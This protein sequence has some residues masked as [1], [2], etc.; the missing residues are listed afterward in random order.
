MNPMK[1]ETAKAW[2]LASGIDQAPDFMMSGNSQMLAARRRLAQ[3]VGACR[4]RGKKCANK[5]W[6]ASAV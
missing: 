1:A 5:A 4:A 6:S 2:E 3:V